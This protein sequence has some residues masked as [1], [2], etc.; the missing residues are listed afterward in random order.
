M[1][2][3]PALRHIFGPRRRRERPRR[4]T[5]KIAKLTVGHSLHPT[6]YPWVHQQWLK[7]F[8]HQA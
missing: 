1:A 8:D 4:T 2:A 3:R 6:K 5:K 7:T